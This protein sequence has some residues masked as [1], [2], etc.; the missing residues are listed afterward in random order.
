MQLDAGNL[1]AQRAV[2]TKDYL[3]TEKG[4]DASRITVRTGIDRR[5]DEVKTTWFPPAQPSTPTSRAPRQSMKRTVQPQT[6]KPLRPRK[7]GITIRR[8]PQLQSCAVGLH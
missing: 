2:N 5:A 4:I 3:V 6:R 1:A 8:R 7:P